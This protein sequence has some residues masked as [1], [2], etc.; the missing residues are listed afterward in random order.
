MLSMFYATKVNR[1]CQFQH[2]PPLKLHEMHSMTRKKRPL[3]S[4]W[5]TLILGKRTEIDF[6]E[7]RSI[8]LESWSIPFLWWSDNSHNRTNNS[9][10]KCCLNSQRNSPMIHS[11]YVHISDFPTISCDRKYSS[12]LISH[13]KREGAENY[14]NSIECI[15]QKQ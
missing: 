11:I 4:M 5:C 9:I 2:S 12:K 15:G 10:P 7:S 13:S 6:L 1:S 3:T 14:E 8:C